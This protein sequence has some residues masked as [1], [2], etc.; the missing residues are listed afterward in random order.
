MLKLKVQSAFAV[1][2]WCTVKLPFAAMIQKSVALMMFPACAVWGVTLTSHPSEHVAAVTVVLV[3]LVP[4]V[5]L[6]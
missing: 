5:K 3:T 2:A 6:P 1:E 4:R